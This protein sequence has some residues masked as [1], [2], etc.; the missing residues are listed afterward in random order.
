VSK[1]LLLML[2][3]SIYCNN[4]CL[5]WHGSNLLNP[6]NPKQEHRIG[7]AQ[8]RSQTVYELLAT[9][10]GLME[11]LLVGLLASD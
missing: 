11:G 1:N 3:L 5:S 7:M 9:E 2:M 6:K 10:T 4:G 8:Q